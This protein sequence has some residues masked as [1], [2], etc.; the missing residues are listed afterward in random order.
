MGYGHALFAV[1]V[2]GDEN[3]REIFVSIKLIYGR[4]I[5]A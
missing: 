2:R 1:S 5:V 4:I 3:H